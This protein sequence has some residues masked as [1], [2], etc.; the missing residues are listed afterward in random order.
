MSRKICRTRLSS[1]DLRCC[2]RIFLEEL[3]DLFHAVSSGIGRGDIQKDFMCREHLKS[4][5]SCSNP[6]P[7]SLL[8]LNRVRERICIN[9]CRR[10]HSTLLMTDWQKF[11]Y[12]LKEQQQQKEKGSWYHEHLDPWHYIAVL[13]CFTYMSRYPVFFIRFWKYACRHRILSH[14]LFR[15]TTH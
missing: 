2:R 12:T 9:Y 3:R 1:P 4:A 10:T 14:V 11:H 5:G 7:R 13:H 6:F 15:F 8:L